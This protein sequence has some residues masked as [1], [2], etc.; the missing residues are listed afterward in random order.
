MQA[1]SLYQVKGETPPIALTAPPHRQLQPIESQWVLVKGRLYMLQLPF[2]L[3]HT[4]DGGPHV[5][6]WNMLVLRLDLDLLPDCSCRLPSS[7]TISHT[8]TTSGTTF[9][10]G[11]S[12]ASGA[13]S[14][15]AVL[16]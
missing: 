6:L 1:R 11:W 5:A 16:R 8:P 9:R 10:P 15:A 3:L 12:V 7:M 4:M 2:S 13:S 14:C